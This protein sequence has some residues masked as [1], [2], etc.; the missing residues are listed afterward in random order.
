MR[1]I[2]S[3]SDPSTLRAAW[4]AAAGA[5]VLV[6]AQCV[7]LILL[8][9]LAT[10]APVVMLAEGASGPAQAAQRLAQGPLSSS[11][12]LLQAE[13]ARY[14]ARRESLD[15]QSF[16]ADFRA[17]ALASSS[18]ARESYLAAWGK[19]GGALGSVTTETRITAR[20]LAVEIIE[21]GVALADVAVTRQDGAGPAPG[22]TQ[23]RV[24]L[25]FA[26]S[27][28]A[29]SPRDRLANPLGLIVSTYQDG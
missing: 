19:G 21:P 6:I 7:G 20:V 16:A 5:S 22:P 18:A 27:D 14:I 3:A 17:T 29:L 26:V 15:P 23:R 13:I 2:T 10:P 1:A 25:S 11:P 8:Q 28:R 9:P 4:A 24:R 12:A